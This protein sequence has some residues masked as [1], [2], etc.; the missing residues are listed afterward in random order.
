METNVAEK[1]DSKRIEN[2]NASTKLSSNSG[3]TKQKFSQKFIIIMSVLVSI[4]VYLI[5]LNILDA[6]KLG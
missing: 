4:F 6:V 3:L 5:I 1:S 2:S